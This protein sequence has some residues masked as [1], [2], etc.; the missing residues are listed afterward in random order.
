MKRVGS[1]FIKQ[2][3]NSKLNYKQETGSQ[4]KFVNIAFIC[5]MHSYPTQKHK[6]LPVLLKIRILAKKNIF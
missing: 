2:S 1:N 4:W 6:N 5:D 3:K